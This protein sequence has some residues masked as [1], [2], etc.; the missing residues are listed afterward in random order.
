MKKSVSVLLALALALT[1][2][3]SA[4]ADDCAVY[5]DDVLTFAYPAAYTVD[6]AVMNEGVYM[7]TLSG[8]D[9]DAFQLILVEGIPVP[10]GVYADDSMLDSISD[11]IANGFAQ[12]S[13][14][15]ATLQHDGKATYGEFLV[16][17]YTGSML[18]I[19][20]LEACVFLRDN[21][22]TMVIVVDSDPAFVLS[23]VVQSLAFGG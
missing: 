11:E 3:V 14:G 5:S 23:T 18:G 7:V 12:G 10:A 6:G 16:N 13:S 20:D 1:C 9:P 19:V 8:P 15:L 2:C 22:I 17:H 21:Y 4:F